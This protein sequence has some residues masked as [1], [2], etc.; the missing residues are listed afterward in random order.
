MGKREVAGDSLASR[1]PRPMAPELPG[2]GAAGDGGGGGEKGRD[3]ES[4]RARL[5]RLDE[6][7]VQP[8]R[9]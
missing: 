5:R 4:T 3:S 1:M 6:K 9:H 2:M 7:A 8:L